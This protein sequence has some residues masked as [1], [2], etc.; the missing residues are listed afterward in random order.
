MKSFPIQQRLEHNKTK[1]KMCNDNRYI[2]SV[3]CPLS[4]MYYKV[5]GIPCKCSEP[6]L[7]STQPYGTERNEGNQNELVA[8]PM[9]MWLWNNQNVSCVQETARISGN[10]F[11]IHPYFCL[12]IPEHDNLFVIREA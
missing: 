12:A 4:K 11:S 7:I 10:A 5:E 3:Y 9:A 6:P 1:S 2:F 8:V